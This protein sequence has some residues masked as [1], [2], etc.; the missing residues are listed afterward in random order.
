MK[1]LLYFVVLL[2]AVLTVGCQGHGGVYV[3]RHADRDGH[4]DRLKD[5]EGIAR[6]DTL[7]DRLD[8]VE[9]SAIYSTSLS[10]TRNTAQ[11]LADRL[12]LPVQTYSSV[13]AIVSHI[14]A[15]HLEEL[16][17]VV[18]HSNTVPQIVTGLGAELPANLVLD[19]SGN[20]PHD[21]Y[22]NLLFVVFNDEGGAGA[23]LVEYGAPS[24]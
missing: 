22:D 12:G 16:V 23:G 9:I 4:H 8:D 18:G 20:I 1:T 3:V 13:S 15:H 21:H 19:S 5:P 14:K 17:L 11:P 10:R 2:G 7:A 6:A 24:P